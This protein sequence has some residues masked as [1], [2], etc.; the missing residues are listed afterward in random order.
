MAFFVYIQLSVQ[1]R[2]ASRLL[3]QF[4]LLREG[5]FHL[6]LRRRLLLMQG[7]QLVLGGGDSLREVVQGIIQ[8]DDIAQRVCAQRHRVLPLPFQKS[9]I[10]RAESIKSQGQLKAP[11]AADDFFLGV[12]QLG[13]GKHQTL[14]GGLF[15]IVGHALDG[16]AAETLLHLRMGGGKLCICFQPGNV[17]VRF[18]NVSRELGQQFVLQAEFLALVVSFQHLQLCHLHIQVHLLLD[19]RISGAQHLDLCIGKRLLVHILAGA[20]RGFAGHNLRD[21]SLFV[22]QS[23]P[24]VGVKCPFRDIVE[25]LDFLIHIALPNDASVALGH[26]AGLPANIQMMHRH[27]SGLD[28]GARSH[29]CCTSEQNPHITGAHFGEQCRLFCFGIGVVDELDLVLRHTGSD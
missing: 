10:L 3:C 4:F 20:H 11:V 6:D 29:F 27:K 16:H 17:S 18:L 14:T 8:T 22:L 7:G 15:L 1:L 12:G 21:K 2:K 28:V 26:V 25:H 24:E 5:F 13:T 19:E 23:L 9:L